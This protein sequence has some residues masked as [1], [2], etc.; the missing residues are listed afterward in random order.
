MK[1]NPDLSLYVIIDADYL[2]KINKSLKQTLVSSLKAGATMIQ[3]RGKTLDD[4][5]FLKL[6]RMM[7]GITKKYRVPLIIND[8]AGIAKKIGADG[9]H[10]GQE[11]MPVREA[12]RILKKGEIIG[13]SASTAGEARRADRENADYIGLGPV[14]KTKNKDTH[15]I[16]AAT[17]TKIISTLRLPVVAIGGI[18]EYNIDVLKKAGLKNFCFISEI[19]DAENIYR[20]VKDLK[21]K[22][23]DPA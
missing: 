11:D 13:V 5:R 20:K 6:A 8:R 19:A 10:L 9:V 21:E 3:F 7:K 17:L 23:N 15:P 4:G 2:K 1:K 16:P 18:K 12:R 22:I 14:F